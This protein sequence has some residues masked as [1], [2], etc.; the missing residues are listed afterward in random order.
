ML[1]LISFR[2]GSFVGQRQTGPAE[3][4]PSFATTNIP[5][6]LPSKDGIPTRLNQRTARRCSLYFLGRGEPENPVPFIL[7]SSINSIK[8]RLGD[9][10]LKGRQRTARIPPIPNP[11]GNFPLCRTP[12]YRGWRE[13][14]YRETLGSRRPGWWLARVNLVFCFLKYPWGLHSTKGQ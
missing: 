12:W 7:P 13:E 8:N 9:V 6:R 10:D 5:P 1:L 4:T 2:R 3:L 14:A 11:Q